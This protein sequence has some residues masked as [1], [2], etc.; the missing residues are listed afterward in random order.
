MPSPVPNH[1]YDPA[2]LCLPPA[3]L[4]ALLGRPEAP[5]LIDVSIDQDF[6]ADPHLLPG[7][8][9]HP[10]RDIGALAPV[11]GTRAAVLVCQK[12][13]KLSQGAAAALRARG[14]AAWALEG[15]NLA[16][17]QAGL[18]RIRADV[19]PP[20]CGAA[21]ADWVLASGGDPRGLAGAWLVRRFVDPRA[22]FWFVAAGEVADVADR[23]S[24][25]A[26]PADAANRDGLAALLAHFG[27]HDAALDRLA[28]LLAGAASAPLAPVDAL[29]AA[30]GSRHRGDNDRLEA[31]LGLCDLLHEAC[32]TEPA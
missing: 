7:A 21:G 30:L 16:W 1:P 20:G 18:P 32:G 26:F 24:V 19:L 10:H 14:G 17:R 12:G 31:A 9:R 8:F 28:G 6:A 13:R 25:A 2:A 5:V 4:R 3:T 27:L 22:R 11:L 23:F 29:F 15:G